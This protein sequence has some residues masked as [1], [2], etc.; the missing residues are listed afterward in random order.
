MK[1]NE[2]KG[3][4]GLEQEIKNKG[5]I[6]LLEE[7][8]KYFVAAVTKW[9]ML[10]ATNASEPVN[11]NTYGISSV[12]RVTKKFLEVSRCG[13]A[14]Q[15]RTNV[16]KS[17]LHARSCFFSLIRPIVVFHCSPA[18]PSPLSIT[19]FYII[20]FEQTINIIGSFVFSPG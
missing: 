15:R 12:K 19:R 20:L 8:H 14:K 11:G 7:Q 5:D 3:D 1:L 17:V 18:L 2:K 13:Q 6:F 9:E 4:R 10:A 16:Q